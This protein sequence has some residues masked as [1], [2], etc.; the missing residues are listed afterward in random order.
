MLLHSR[1]LSCRI[2]IS[3]LK[4]EKITF[5]YSMKN[6]PVPPRNTYMKKLI[7]KTESVIKRMRWK[8]FFSEKNND[9]TQHTE[10][11]DNKYGFKT[12]KCPPQNES[13]NSFEADMLEMIRNIT[14]NNTRDEFQ[15]QLKKDIKKLNN[16]T[17]A[18][19]PADKTSNYYEISKTNHSKL[20]TDSI[21]STYKK[22][23]TTTIRKINS[24]AKHIANKLKIDDRAERMAEREAF[25]TLKDHKENFQ[26]NPT[27]R[28][29]NPAKSEIGRISKQIL[30][31]RK[32]STLN[33][34]KNSSAVINWF[35]NIPHKQQHSLV[36]FD[37]EN[38]YP[39]ITERLLMDAVNFA[40]TYVNIPQQDIDIIKHS[41]KS[42]LF[43]N[44]LAW[45]KKN[46][47][48][49][50]IT[51][52]SFDGAEVCELV[53]LFLL[54][55]LCNKYGVNN[56]GLYRD[57]GL[58]ILKNKSGPQ[59]DRVRKD[60]TKHF[61]NHGLNIT[62]QTNLKIVN[63]LDVTFNLT[64][65][66]YCPYRKP[67]DTPLYINTQSNHPPN[68]I[69]QLPK[70]INDRISDISCNKDEFDKARQSTKLH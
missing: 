11:Q 55:G 41:R 15:Q 28:L 65:E 43:S 70:A 6:I 9:T 59:A 35:S 29:I 31:E 8:A 63:Y 23:D 14:Y 40:K 57:D 60:I 5:N 45:T 10:E 1:A 21:T 53:G 18:F 62:I 54:N 13:L 17:K 32:Q 47:N 36:I 12:R 51:M 46:S 48:M 39:S 20:L 67:N 2:L 44:G 49:F 52:G 50:D 16:S 4:M 26:N 7:E 61:K 33:Q 66:T 56:I 37:I 34:W 3:A 27:C 69:K 38:F 24:E 64:N 42:L 58:G 68:I 22:T 25:I 19:I 30:E